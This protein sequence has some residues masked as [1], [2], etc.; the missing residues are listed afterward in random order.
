MYVCQREI[1]DD[2]PRDEKLAR[3]EEMPEI[4]YNE[5]FSMSSVMGDCIDRAFAQDGDEVMEAILE[6]IHATPIGRVLRRISTLPE[7][8]KGKV[9]NLRRQIT[10]GTYDVSDR[11]D[12]AL[13]SVLEDL[14]S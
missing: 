10:A 4:Q 8:R 5:S 3:L 1:K 11:L 14:M 7:I 6:N 9:L 12:D 2:C 13:D